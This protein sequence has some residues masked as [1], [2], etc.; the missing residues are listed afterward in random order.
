M[1]IF[2]AKCLNA[3]DHVTVSNQV[4]SGVGISANKYAISLSAECLNEITSKI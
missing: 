3:I 2:S 1:A 4:V